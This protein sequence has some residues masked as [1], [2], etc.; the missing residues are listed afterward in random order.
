MP[1]EN[2]T[3]PV[4]LII[5][6]WQPAKCGCK[7]S[8]SDGAGQFSDVHYITLCDTHRGGTGF[9]P[10]EVKRDEN[11]YWDHPGIPAF[12]GEDPA[13]YI[14][15]ADEQKLERKGWHMLDELDSHPYE[16]GEAHCNGWEPKS[17]GPEWF[18]MGIFD[19]EDGPYVNWARR[20]S[21]QVTP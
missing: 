21:Q 2:G 18:L 16:D 19:T 8:F 15:W 4:Q 17:P 14:A 7:M 5:V 6:N 9:G 11:G 10:V 12:E 20:I 13:P 1:E 3:P